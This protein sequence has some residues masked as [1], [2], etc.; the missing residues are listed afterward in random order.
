M[1]S[2]WKP[3]FRMSM[4]AVSTLALLAVWPL[5][6]LTDTCHKN[7]NF[8]LIAGLIINHLTSI[9]FMHLGLVTWD[10]WTLS[11]D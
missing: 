11:P 9:D 1:N 7:G 10:F 8:P 2:L 6:S 3:D 5:F 4:N